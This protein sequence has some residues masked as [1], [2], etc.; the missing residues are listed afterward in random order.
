MQSL[1]GCHRLGM[2][3]KEKG[4]HCDQAQC[5][6]LRVPQDEVR[7]AGQG[8]ACVWPCCPG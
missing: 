1:C 8:P 6:A 4:R 7:R 2:F 3:G 5:Q